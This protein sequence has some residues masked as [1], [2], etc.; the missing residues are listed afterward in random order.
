[1]NHASGPRGTI[2]KWATHIE[3]RAE[4]KHQLV[5]TYVA[6]NHASGPHGAIRRWTKYHDPQVIANK[7]NATADGAG[8]T[9]NAPS[10]TART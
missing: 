3:L 4:R 1:M 2:R 10:R 5:I 8:S 9:Q 6:I 7:Q